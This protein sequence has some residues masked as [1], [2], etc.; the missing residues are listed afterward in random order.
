[1]TKRERAAAA[2][3]RRDMD[4]LL[5]RISAEVAAYRQMLTALAP[6]KF[7]ERRRILALS[8]TFYTIDP[9]KVTV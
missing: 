5:D 6:L 8:A 1:M 4:R 2:C 9:Q 3:R 7:E